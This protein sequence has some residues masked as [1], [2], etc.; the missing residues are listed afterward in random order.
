MKKFILFLF[1][2]SMLTAGAQD[3]LDRIAAI[4]DDEIILDSEV[5]Q[6]AWLMASQMG[7]DPV[8]DPAQ[9]QKMRRIA[10]RNL[11]NKEL[12]VI[13]ADLDTIKADERQVDAYLEQQMQAAI[14]QA[15]GESRLEEALGMPLSQI[16]RNYRKEIEKE[17]RANT[18]QEKK[19]SKIKLSRRE[20]RQFYESKKD[21]IGRINESVD[22]SHILVE[23]KPGESARL[24]ALDRA[25]QIRRRL[26]TGADFAEL[27]KAV[28]DDPGSAERGGDLGF[29]SRT[30][31]VREYVEAAVKLQPGE[32]SDVVE[33]QF[34]FHIIKMEEKRGD[35]LRTRHIL[36]AIKPKREDELAAAEKIKRI[37]QELMNGAD[38]EEMVLKYSD[39]ASTKN[40]KGHLGRYEVEQLRRMA[41]E[42][43]FALTGLK[44]GE[45]SDPVKTSYGFHI[46]KLNA[47]EQ[48]RELDFDKDYDRIEQAALNYKR[49]QELQK[50]LNELKKQVF[51][52]IKDPDLQE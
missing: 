37:H 25:M 34:G 27:A 36:V 3:L 7:I 51:V 9:F 48:A 40:D 10:L 26:L 8:R 24:E 13:Q 6:T 50:W 11:V 32:I 23:I 49:Q 21:S 47:R 14:Q 16:R 52:E 38:F 41:K 18:V 42:F 5:T 17:L 31:L 44:P 20:V 22:I 15:G 46:L 45:I 39:D 33:S 29:V 35:K 19:L 43:V 30:D 1:L 12:L 28:S 4:V 2:L